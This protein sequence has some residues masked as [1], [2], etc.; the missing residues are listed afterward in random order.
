[1]ATTLAP[2][3]VAAAFGRATAARP[4]R[5][6]VAVRAM[7]ALSQDELKKQVGP[8]R[9]MGVVAAHGAWRRRRE[10]RRR[11]Q[12][13]LPPGTHLPTPPCRFRAAGCLEGG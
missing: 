4:Q 1:M 8:E 10:R 6:I 3:R 9:A 11:R 12:H 13:F 2:Q 5:R 7:A